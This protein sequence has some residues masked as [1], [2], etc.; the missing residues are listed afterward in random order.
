MKYSKLIKMI[1]NLG[2]KKKRGSKHLIFNHPDCDFP[3]IVPNHG[4]KEVPTGTAAKILKDA[5]SIRKKI[6][7]Q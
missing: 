7:K 4:G 5:N 3:L 2:W 1:T 6:K